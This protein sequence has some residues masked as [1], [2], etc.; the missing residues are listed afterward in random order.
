M[1][2]FLLF[3]I[4][5]G[6]KA[7]AAANSSMVQF[8]AS[9][10]LVQAGK[11]LFQHNCSGCH[12]IDAMGKGPASTMLNPKPRN[13]VAG[14]FKFRS[15]PL[16]TLPTNQ[17]LLRTID[18]GVLGTSMP[19][20]PLLS[21]NQKYALVAYIKSL[22]P[23]WDKNVGK[24]Y[25]IPEAPKEIFSNKTLFLAS[26]LR[27]RKTFEEGCLTCH[28]DK[29][30][31]DGPSAEGLIDTD[32]NPIRP[33]NLTRPRIKSGKRAEDVFK[34]IL[35]GLDGTPM[36]SFYGLYDE[37]QIWELVSYVFFLRGQAAGIYGQDLALN[38]SLLKA[39]TQFKN[40]HK[41]PKK[42]AAPSGG[43]WQ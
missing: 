39:E 13:L 19:G 29:G 8:L 17:D 5:T 18:Q 34:V 3:C 38:D 32:D 28:G 15:T 14:A 35:T 42:A 30:H 21:S 43:G 9:Q 41:Q 16:G 22:R 37:T 40:P 6:A 20:F 26:A 23:D 33:A 27:G 11:E 12:G 4:F 7:Q 24:A 36:P 25:T 2:I 1:R 10:Q 31:G